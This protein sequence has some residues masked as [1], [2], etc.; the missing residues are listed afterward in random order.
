MRQ[1]FDA[2]I[3]FQSLRRR[4]YDTA[5]AG[6]LLGL[7]A[8]SAANAGSAESASRPIE[9][10]ASVTT[11]ANVPP[12]PGR[13]VDVGGYR[14]HLH[15]TGSGAP[16][17]ILESGLGGFSLEWDAVQQ[18]L[19]DSRRVCSYDR[20]GYG[21]SDPGPS[22]RTAE[23]LVSELRTMLT[24]AAVPAP[25][26]LVGH[27]FG[28]FLAQLFAKT[29]PQ[30]TAGIVLVD[31]SNPD[32]FRRFPPA[33]QALLQQARGRRSG[34]GSEI[35]LPSRYPLRWRAIAEVLDQQ[36]KTLLAVALEYRAFERSGAQVLAAGAMPDIPGV[37]LTRGDR[38][39]PAGADGDAMEALWPQLQDEL[40]ASLPHSH[41]FN[42]GGSGHHIH[43]DKPA[44][45]DEAV[46][47]VI[48]EIDCA[49]TRIANVDGAIGHC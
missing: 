10:P 35:E 20:G 11:E 48:E 42:V 45:V 36:P 7:V 8:T 4:V 27:S 5:A 41:H 3:I 44:V 40:A 16:T 43:L 26:V 47:L 9:L 46:N 33:Q 28:G 6:V 14:L 32:Q 1:T 12:P 18:Q 37:V 23:H 17:V 25:Y 21:W 34:R 24:T 22:P 39:W 38:E 2:A 31:S 13:L 19:S 29:Y 49:P 15:C 30:L